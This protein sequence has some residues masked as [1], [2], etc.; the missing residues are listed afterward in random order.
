VHVGGVRV[1]LPGVL[2]R[3]VGEVLVFGLATTLTAP[4][5]LASLMAFFDHSPVFR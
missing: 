2:G 3:G 5:F 4:Y 1:E